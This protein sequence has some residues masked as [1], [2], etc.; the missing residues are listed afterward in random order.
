MRLTS[1]QCW[2]HLSEGDH[3]VLCTTGAR[4]AIDAVPV[5]FV[6]VGKMLASP[7][8]TVKAK[9]TTELGRL[10]NLA[11]DAT[12]TLL[13]ERWVRHDWSQLWWVRAQLVRRSDHD[14]TSTRRE[15]FESALRHKYFQY[16]GTEFADLIVFEV[17][18]VSGWA[19]SGDSDTTGTGEARVDD[20]AA[21]AS[22]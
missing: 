8:D 5:C 3:G 9:D 4:G 20:G 18:G 17:K 7:I 14:L 2:S 22:Y 10:K 21:S 12:A 16:R 6:V 13:C 1:D 19:A 11:R 15:E